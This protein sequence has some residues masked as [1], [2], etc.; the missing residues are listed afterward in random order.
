MHAHTHT[1]LPEICSFQELSYS[2]VI[3]HISPTLNNVSDAG[4]V[5]DIIVIGPKTVMG[6]TNVYEVIS[7][8]LVEDA[9]Y[10]VFVQFDTLAGNISS[11]TTFSK[12]SIV[13]CKLPLGSLQKWC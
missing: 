6:C 2:I 3:Q 13:F 12:Q 7:S 9:V 8:G 1:Q 10:S 5:D 11:T 4:G